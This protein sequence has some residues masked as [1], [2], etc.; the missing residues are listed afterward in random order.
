MIKV[1]GQ[2]IVKPLSIIFKNCI[3]D[4]IFPDIWKKSNII[5][6]HKKRDKQVIDH[7][8]PVSLLPICNKIFQKL[9]V[10]SIFKFLDD[11]NLLSSNQSGFR[12]SDSCDYQLLSIVHDIYVSF[13]CCPSPVFRGI[14]L[15]IY[16]AFDLVWHE[17]LI[18]KLQS[19]GMS[20][21]PLKCIESFLSNKFQRVLLN[22]QSSS[23]SPVP[24]SVPQGSILG[25]LYYF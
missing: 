21:L 9:L 5:P 19:L 20:G 17:G 16:K 13:D 18:Y 12:P 25:P 8:R 14:F 4:G 15:D 6:V 1:W 10:T 11:N 3:N 24:A 22:G 23:W 2:S 7:Y